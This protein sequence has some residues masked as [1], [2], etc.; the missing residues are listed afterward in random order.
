MWLIV[1]LRSVYIGLYRHQQAASFAEKGLDKITESSRILQA[2]CYEQALLN[3]QR[4]TT[5]SSRDKG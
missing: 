3:A 1:S 4:D 2:V 5:C